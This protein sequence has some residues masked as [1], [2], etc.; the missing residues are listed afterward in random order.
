MGFVLIFAGIVGIVAGIVGKSFSAE[1]QPEFK[2]PTWLGRLI[3]LTVG[4]LFMAG[5]IKLLLDA[6]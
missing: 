3:F 6:N 1:N 2:I 4:V 5:G